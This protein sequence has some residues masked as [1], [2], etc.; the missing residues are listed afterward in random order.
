MIRPKYYNPDS[1]YEPRKVIKAWGADFNIGSALKYIA[2]A[3][4]KT[5]SPLEDLQKAI[6]YLQF[7]IEEYEHPKPRPKKH[8]ES[9]T[10]LDPA[11]AKELK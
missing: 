3:G 1:V 2:R 10:V 7:A 8:I 5:K 11:A 9:D 6:T 4:H